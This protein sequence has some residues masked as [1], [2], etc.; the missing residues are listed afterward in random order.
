MVRIRVKAEL[1]VQ[2]IIRRKGTFLSNPHRTDQQNYKK[3]KSGE[4]AQS[5]VLTV[6]VQIH[7]S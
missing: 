5:Q 7:K 6:D 4:K 1:S 3:E 2:H